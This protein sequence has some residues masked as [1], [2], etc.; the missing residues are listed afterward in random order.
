MQEK[1]FLQQNWL[2]SPASCGKA[3]TGGQARIGAGMRRGCCGLRT[4]AQGDTAHRQETS[5]SHPSK[6]QQRQGKAQEC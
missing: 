4:L 2:L 1:R 3:E 6:S 5:H